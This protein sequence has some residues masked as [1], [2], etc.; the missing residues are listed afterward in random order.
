MKRMP[1]LLFLGLLS[2][3]HAQHLSLKIGT[4]FRR[5]DL[6]VRWKLTTNDMPARVW[7]Y[8]LL[9]NHF[10]SNL[11]SNLVALGEFTAKDLVSSNA[12]ELLFRKTD[13]S[14]LWISSRLGAIEYL[15][16]GIHSTTNL[17]EHV[18][19]MSELPVLTTN[20]LKEVGIRVED[21]EKRADGSPDFHFSEPFMVYFMDHKPITNIEWRAVGFRR[22][23]EGARF[24]GAGAGGNCHVEF[25][26]YGRPSRIRLS[27]RNL[28]RYK[29]YPTAPPNVIVK[30]IQQGK[31]V[32]NMI[33]MDAEPIDWK[34]VKSVTITSTKLC[35]YGGSPFEPEDWLMPFVALWATVDRGHGTIDVE[36]DCP[37]IDETARLKG[38]S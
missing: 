25:G 30:W 4:P 24:V 11:V 33:R 9:P 32:Q 31:A 29:A 14:S 37:V 21:I 34:T 10:S 2:T 28:Q 15:P 5:P 35:Y 19:T 17:A 20:F 26:E 22:A 27:W 13:F 23:I 16:G 36:I 7:V 12:N 1:L 6:D 3:A 18:P 8:R 38:N